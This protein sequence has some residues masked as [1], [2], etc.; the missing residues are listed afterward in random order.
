MVK[1]NLFELVNETAPLTVVFVAS[2]GAAIAAVRSVQAVLSFEP[3][4][5]KLA[6]VAAKICVAE[7]F[8]M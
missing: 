3:C 8:L 2:A 7:V 6:A 5:F 4:T 1:V